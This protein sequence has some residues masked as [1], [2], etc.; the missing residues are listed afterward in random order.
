MKFKLQVIR[1]LAILL[2]AGSWVSN[3]SQD[4]KMPITRS[5]NGFV[6]RNGHPCTEAD[7]KS[8]RIAVGA[9]IVGFVAVIVTSFMLAPSKKEENEGQPPA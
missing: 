4:H 5:A 8:G 6:D 7:Y 9:F 2:M 3:F 1:I